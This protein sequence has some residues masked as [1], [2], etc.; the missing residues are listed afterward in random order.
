M[1]VLYGQPH[2][3]GNKRE[4]EPVSQWV[5]SNR[6]KCPRRSAWTLCPARGTKCQGTSP[7]SR[8]T[9]S[10]STK[11]WIP[12]ISRPSH[13]GTIFPNSERLIANYLT[14]SSDSASP[15]L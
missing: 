6:E 4:R 7:M 2:L 1:Y 3:A 14:T 5:P 10:G 12:Y 11:L 8:L 15:F 9:P 13:N